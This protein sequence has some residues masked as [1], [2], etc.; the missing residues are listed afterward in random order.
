MREWAQKYEKHEKEIRKE[1][2]GNE[3]QR[4]NTQPNEH[5]SDQRGKQR[6]HKAIINIK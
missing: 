4:K 1:E 5:S 3:K 6:T 2:T